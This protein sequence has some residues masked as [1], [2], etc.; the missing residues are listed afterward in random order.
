MNNL[1]LINHTIRLKLGLSLTEYCLIDL[2]HTDWKG[3]N[4]LTR[5]ELGQKFG[6]SKAS[7]ITCLKNLIASGLMESDGRFLTTTEKWSSMFDDPEETAPVP[8]APPSMWSGKKK[9]AV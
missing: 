9:L 5:N 2:F 4:S 8:A 7:V 3:A 6:M 1:T